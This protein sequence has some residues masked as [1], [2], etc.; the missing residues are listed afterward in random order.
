MAV[1]QSKNKYINSVFEN[2]QTN[3]ITI[4][5]DKLINKLTIYTTK[6][7]KGNDWI[8]ALGILISIGLTL[9]TSSFNI[10]FGISG[11]AWFLFFIFM[12]FVIFVYFCY[13]LYN[14]F[15]NRTSIQDV[16]NDIKT[17]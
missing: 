9:L 3:I 14:A 8:G 7:K 12:A 17:K 2:T 10:T 13:C 1:S 11:D 6:I 16:I 4:T 15:K 5:E